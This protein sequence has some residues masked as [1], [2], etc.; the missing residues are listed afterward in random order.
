MDMLLAQS[1]Y[2][3]KSS[4]LP[5]LAEKIE[6]LESLF[7]SEDAPDFSTYFSSVLYD[8]SDMAGWVES[9][10]GHVATGEEGSFHGSFSSMDSSSSTK[11][12]FGEKP[13]LTFYEEVTKF[14]YGEEPASKLGFHQGAGEEI[15]FN[16]MESASSAK[17]GFVEEPEA[18]LPQG[19]K[20]GLVEEHKSE[21]SEGGS[22][23]LG[24]HDLEEPSMYGGSIILEGSMHG[25]SL[26]AS[27]KDDDDGNNGD[28][29]DDYDGDDCDGCDG[30]D[31]I[32][33]VQLLMT[34]ADAIQKKELTAAMAMAQK[35]RR[36]KYKENEPSSNCGHYPF[37]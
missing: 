10:I 25:N 29:C 15:S 3:V 20:A 37:Q 5:L 4:D 13:K 19:P 35:Q 12:G 22:T 36:Q 11:L 21:M 1:G 8:P 33:L 28:G 16:S 2:T 31:G 18:G 34:C 32:W 24:F 7:A 17:L 26:E 14:G 6:H 27:R 30:D 9:L 23:K